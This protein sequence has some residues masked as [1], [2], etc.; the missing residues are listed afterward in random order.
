MALQYRFFGEQVV[1]ACVNNG[2]STVDISG[3]PQVS[4]PMQ[5]AGDM[6]LGRED[7]ALAWYCRGKAL[8]RLLDT[9]CGVKL[10]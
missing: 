5:S 4:W 3:E 7:G 9:F 6:G 2:A 8:L 1:K 10:L